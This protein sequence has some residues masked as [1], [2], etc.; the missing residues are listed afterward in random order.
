MKIDNLDSERRKEEEDRE[1]L[2][3]QNINIEEKMNTINILPIYELN[4]RKKKEKGRS[5]KQGE[6]LKRVNKIYSERK[7]SIEKPSVKTQTVSMIEENI[8]DLLNREPEEEVEIEEEE[9][10]DDRS[11]VVEAEDRLNNFVRNRVTNFKN[12]IMRKQENMFNCI[13]QLS[14]IYIYIYILFIYIK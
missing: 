9:E 11:N 6:R 5:F 3:A 4:E 10:E 2:K 13:S 12:E 14:V 1:M 7:L 8:D